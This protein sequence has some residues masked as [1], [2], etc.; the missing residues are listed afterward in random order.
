MMFFED[1][2]PLR[3]HRSLTPIADKTGFIGDFTAKTFQPVADAPPPTVPT[4]WLPTARVARAWRAVLTEQ[5][6]EP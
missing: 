1:V 5:P 4:A 6:F 3:V 2:L